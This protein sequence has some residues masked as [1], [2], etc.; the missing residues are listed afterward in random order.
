MARNHNGKTR[1]LAVFIVALVGLAA[2]GASTGS[3]TSKATSPIASS[4]ATPTTPGTAPKVVLSNGSAAK[5]AT[6]PADPCAPVLKALSSLGWTVTSSEKSATVPGSPNDDCTF[7]GSDASGT[8]QQESF[9][10]W[11]P[12]LRFVPQSALT[13]LAGLSVQAWSDKTSPKHIF[14]SGDHPFQLSMNHGD[15]LITLATELLKG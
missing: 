4:S 1:Q 9:V 8:D 3:G 6:L 15:N 10:I 5:D 14:V 7:H 2:C 11:M 12:T 13:P